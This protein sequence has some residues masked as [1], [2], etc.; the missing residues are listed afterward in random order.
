MFTRI[1]KTDDEQRLVFAEVIIPGLIDTQGDMFSPA[2]VVKIAHKFL[3]GM[4]NMKIDVNHDNVERGSYVVESFIARDSD[5]Q[6]IPGAWVVGVKVDQDTWVKVKSGELN[7]FSIEFML[8]K[9]DSIKVEIDSSL[10]MRPIVGDTFAEK[11]HKHVYTI[12][13]SDTGQIVKGV[14]NIVAGHSHTISNSSVTDFAVGHRHKFSY[15][16]ILQPRVLE[17]L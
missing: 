14:T 10:F 3:S 2:A 16:D 15:W 1:K 17:S 4:L 5:D 7:G 6:F 11:D 9:A 8:S 13:L 12:Q